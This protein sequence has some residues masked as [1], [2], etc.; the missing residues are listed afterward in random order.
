[1]NIRN[2]E[3]TM[4]KDVTLRNIPPVSTP[5]SSSPMCH[6]SISMKKAPVFSPYIEGRHSITRQSTNTSILKLPNDV[7]SHNSDNPARHKLYEGITKE[8]T[9]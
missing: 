6:S 1:M 5:G 9:T 4:N 7:A 3:D 2:G 8:Y